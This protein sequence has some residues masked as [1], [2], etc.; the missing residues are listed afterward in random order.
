MS[1][2]DFLN[3]NPFFEFPSNL[4]SWV[5][6]VILV[7]LIL[8]LFWKE[9]RSSKPNLR[10]RW[11]ILLIGLVA[12]P[13]TTILLKTPLSFLPILPIPGLP[14]ESLVP[15]IF[16]LISLPWMLIAGLVSSIGAGIIGLFS[17]IWLGLWFTHSIYSPV[18]FVLLAFFFAW[19]IRQENRGWLFRILGHPLAA[20]YLLALINIPLVILTTFWNTP[21]SLAVKIDYSLGQS[22]TLVLARSGEIILGGI[23]TEVIFLTRVPYWHRPNHNRLS[24]IETSLKSRYLF[25]LI[26][27]F[28]VLIF[29]L[30][31]AGWNWAAKTARE[32]IENRLID[33]A[34]IVTNTIP[35]FLNTGQ[36][37]ISHQE[38]PEINEMG[39][40]EI[41]IELENILHKEIFFD[42]IAFINAES[43]KIT[44]DSLSDGGELTEEERYGVDLALKGVMVQTYVVTPPGGYEQISISFIASV[45]SNQVPAGVLVGRA[46]LLSNPVT[47]TAINLIQ[48]LSDDGGLGAILDEDLKIIYHTTG[49][50]LMSDFPTQLPNDA[51]TFEGLSPQGKRMLMYFQTSQGRTWSVVVGLPAELIQQTAL[52]LA[53]PQ[54]LL[55]LTI[56]VI[57]IA[58]LLIGL[59]TIT[60]GMRSAA[61]TAIQVSNGRLDIPLQIK[62]EDEVGQLGLAFEAMRISLKKRLEELNSLLVVSQGVASNLKIPDAIMP[63]L[64][65]ALRLNAS[66]VRIVIQAEG[67]LEGTEE[68]KSAFGIGQNQEAYAYLDEQILDLCR[69]QP[70]LQLT[71]LGRSRRLSFPSGTTQPNSLLALALIYEQTYLGVIWLAFT[72]PKTVTDEETQ[73]LTTLAAQAALAIANARLFTAAEI[74]KQRLE[75]VLKSAP[76]PILVF[77][78][79]LN[80][81]LLNAAALQV[82]ELVASSIPGKPLN[83]V[84]ANPELQKLVSRPIQDGS[85]TDEITLSNKRVYFISI[86]QV[87]SSGKV[88]GRVCILRDITYYKNLDREK[89]EYVSNVSHDLRSPLTLLRGYITMIQMMGELNEQ[90]QG[91]IK[92]MVTSV[93]SMSAVVEKLLDLGRLESGVGLLI[94]RVMP[95]LIIDEVKNTQAGDAAKK[96]IQIDTSGVPRH[97]VEME[98]DPALLTQAFRNLLENAIKYTPIGGKVTINM[99]E[100]GETILFEV[101]DTGIGIAPLDLPRVFEKFYRSSRR[102]AYAQKGSGLGL[103]IV[104]SIVERH[105][106]KIWV[107]SQLG[108]GSVFYIQLPVKQPRNQNL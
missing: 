84:L 106:G 77:D 100:Q 41:K 69:Y 86:A 105:H 52:Q 7:C 57:V 75:A 78:E 72:D 62:G 12:I 30:T 46:N 15:V 8:W 97:R 89:S 94:G 80:L 10:F 66:S 47:K 92:K 53:I 1:G 51:G 39:E 76:E 31:I 96:N 49:G 50:M 95:I 60:K 16:P 42:E 17:G 68:V 82:P 73:Y 26:P 25:S 61:Q 71:N 81:L 48:W 83:Q 27:V 104:K 45:V 20:A 101:R 4:L 108:K 40:N 91:F 93:D 13:F 55:A 34:K 6:W 14:T 64:E 87:I 44:W 56:A 54:F 9:V 88:M 22:W 3:T 35:Y 63:I 11:W 79:Q 21:G 33:S 67:E 19:M 29:G 37:L 74:G 70:V 98:A 32:Q 107:E 38:I 102:E 23:I 24:S 90:Q 43:G 59:Q 28:L 36:N 85:S 65:G 18:E 103:A 5:G 2:F 58:G 99:H